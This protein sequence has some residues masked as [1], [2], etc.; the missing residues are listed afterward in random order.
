MINLE[1]EFFGLKDKYARQ[2]KE[3]NLPISEPPSPTLIQQDLVR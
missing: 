2:T 3:H 1:K